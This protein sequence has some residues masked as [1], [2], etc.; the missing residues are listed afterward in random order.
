MTL[1][2]FKLKMISELS[3]IYETDDLN[4][5]F[6]LLAEDYLKIPRSKILLA[7]EFD[8]DESNQTLFFSALERLKT[9][10]P[11]Q[12]VL[13]KTNFMDLEF[14]VNSSVLIPR[15]E[16]E[17]LVRL[18]LKEDLDGKEI[19]DI[20]S[21]S[22]CIAI[23]LAKNLPNAKV[24]ALDISNDALEVAKEN[25][26]LN[27]VDIEF[28]NSDIFE[29]QSDKKYDIIVSN[30]PYVLESEKLLMKK[31]VLDFEPELAL[32]VEDINPVIYYEAISWF[33]KNYLNKKG[34]LF[35]EIN[36]NYKNE[37]MFLFRDNFSIEII[38]D[39]SGKNRFCVTA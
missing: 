33:S 28:I 4:S 32:F 16:T 26:T 6:N 18:M 17:E 39:L 29:Y 19:L 34:R 5:I 9:H 3:L 15:P 13:G 20:G 7:N 37:L 1:Q 23:S 30:P 10:E 35:L 27:N 25:A 22:G 36:E 38:K 12:Y 8:L 24:S 14:K 21:G 2:D 11:I 31:N